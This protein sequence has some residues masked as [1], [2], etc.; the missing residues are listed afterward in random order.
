MHHAAYVGTRVLGVAAI[1]CSSRAAHQSGNLAADGKLAAGARLHDAD[2]LNAANRCRFS[3]L[4]TAHVHLGMI[5]SKCLDLNNDFAW[6]WLWFRNLLDD[7]TIQTTEVI[8][9]DGAHEFLLSHPY[10]V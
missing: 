4:S 8:E 10:P 7:Q 6:F 3:P 2:T 5:D 9:Y 1:Y